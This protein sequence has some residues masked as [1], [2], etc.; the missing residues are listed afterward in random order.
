[1]FF[2]MLLLTLFFTQVVSFDHNLV[3][4]LL[5][6]GN[7][8]VKVSHRADGVI[9]YFESVGNTSSQSRNL[10]PRHLDL[11][12]T[13]PITYTSG[14]AR[15]DYVDARTKQFVQAS[16]FELGVCARY[17]RAIAKSFLA[18]ACCPKVKGIKFHNL[19]Y[20]SATAATMTFDYY[21]TAKCTGNG[22][23]PITARTIGFP[24][25][26]GTQPTSTP[27]GLS[28]TTTHVDQRSDALSFGAGSTPGFII[29]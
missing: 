27:V 12:A 17:R 21:D 3:D 24:A 5:C 14:F 10:I 19:V 15:V 11:F 29:S 23:L 1:M 28:Y 25:A 6:S 22:G 26:G 4:S 18:P 9:E 8:S 20:T 16:I 13:Y 2:F 7:N